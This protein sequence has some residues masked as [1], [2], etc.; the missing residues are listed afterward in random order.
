MALPTMRPRYSV[1][2]FTISPSQ[3]LAENQKRALDSDLI[4]LLSSLTYNPPCIEK[5]T[6]DLRYLAASLNS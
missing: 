4:S 6:L 3:T 1:L 5:T 2:G